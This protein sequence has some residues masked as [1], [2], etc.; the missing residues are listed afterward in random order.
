M[1]KPGEI[2]WNGRVATSDFAQAYN[3]AS[4]RIATWEAD[5]LQAPDYLLNGRHNLMAHHAMHLPLPDDRAP[6]GRDSLS[7]W[8]SPSKARPDVPP[9]LARLV[10][11]ETAGRVWDSL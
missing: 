7:Y 11:Q 4:A 3:S 8:Q 5:G 9:S 6:D 1:L 10:G 2:L